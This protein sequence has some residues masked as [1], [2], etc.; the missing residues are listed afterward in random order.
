MVSPRQ[1]PV[2]ARTPTGRSASPAGR[3]REARNQLVLDLAQPDVVDHL[4][5]AIGDVLA[6][7]PI[8][9]IKWDMNRDLT[10]P[11]TPAVP[12][13]R[14]GEFFHRYVLGVYELYSRLTE[15]FPDVLFESC[16]S[17]GA[18]FDAGLLA[19]APQAWTSDDTD[20]V[21]RLRDPV[22]LVASPIR[23][24]RWAPTSR[25]CRTTRS[26]A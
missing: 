14:Q 15:R 5:T 13:E 24:P 21:E 2:R 1:R 9:Y 23:S 6:S 19:Y 4:E 17:G 12:P 3:G 8:D 7:A 10:E 22:G 16:A 26:A 20:A 18:R 11:W 25:R